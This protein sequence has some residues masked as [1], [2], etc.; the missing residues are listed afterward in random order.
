[1]RLAVTLSGYDNVTLKEYIWLCFWLWFQV[2][3]W[4]EKQ[5]SCDPDN[6]AWIAA[7]LFE[8]AGP[9]CIGCVRIIG[10]GQFFYIQSV[11]AENQ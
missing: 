2:G 11:V 3:Y 10:G 8:S 1:M 7:V 9:L 6:R 4:F 5:I